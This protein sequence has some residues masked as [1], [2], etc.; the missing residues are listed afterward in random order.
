[1]GRIFKEEIPV[2]EFLSTLETNIDDYIIAIRSSLK[3]TKTKKAANLYK[4]KKEEVIKMG[5]IFRKEIPF[6]EF[7]STLETN[8]DEYSLR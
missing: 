7:L 1:M 2:S 6:S 3:R 5:R 4:N 8:I